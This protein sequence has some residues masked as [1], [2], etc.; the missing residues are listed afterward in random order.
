MRQAEAVGAFVDIEHPNIPGC[1]V[2]NS[3]VE[4]GSDPHP[5]YRHAPEL[6]AHTEEV[7]LEAGL[8]LGRDRQI[9][10]CRASSARRLE[11]LCL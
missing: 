1:R 7:A 9:E 3:P 11:R 2:V 5:A 4:F 8:S 10:G 6:G